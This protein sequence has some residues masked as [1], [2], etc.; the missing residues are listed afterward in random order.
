MN[1]SAHRSRKGVLRSRYGALA[2]LLFAFFLAPMARAD[3]D[4]ADAQGAESQGAEQSCSARYGSKYSCC[5]F[6]DQ[7][8]METVQTKAC[9]LTSQ[10]YRDRNTVR[11]SR[12]ILDGAGQCAEAP[13]VDFDNP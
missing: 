10:C 3:D 12:I 4:E 6:I 11:Q 5:E 13:K 2:A 7:Q 1:P 9:V 8:G